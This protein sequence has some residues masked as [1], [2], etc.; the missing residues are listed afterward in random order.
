ML[1]LLFEQP[2]TNQ[3]MQPKPTKSQLE[4]LLEVLCDPQARVATRLKLGFYSHHIYITILL[5]MYI[6]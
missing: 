1:S 6:S 4:A 5:D 3:Q 2:K